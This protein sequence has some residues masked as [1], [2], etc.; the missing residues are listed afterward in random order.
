MVPSRNPCREAATL[1]CFIFIGSSLNA[2]KYSRYPEHPIR[3]PPNNSNV[4]FGT[5]RHVLNLCQD[6]SLASK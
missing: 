2:T 5:L 4:Y 6:G 3:K 1:N